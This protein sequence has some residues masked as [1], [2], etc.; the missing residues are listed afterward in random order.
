MRPTIA[1]LVREFDI[2]L[3]DSYDEKIWVEEW[4]DHAVLQ[5]GKLWVHFA[6]RTR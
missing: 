4:K 6:K 2:V 1:R 5:V 3:G